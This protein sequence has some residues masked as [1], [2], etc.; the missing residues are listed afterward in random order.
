MGVGVG[1]EVGARVGVGV[2]STVK[3]TELES[4]VPSIATTSPLAAWAAT[5]AVRAKFP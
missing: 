4:P 3:Y 2:G 5:E 1:V